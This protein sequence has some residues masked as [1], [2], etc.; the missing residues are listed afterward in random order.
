M[1]NA[2]QEFMQHVEDPESVLCATINHEYLGWYDDDIEP[3]SCNLPVNHTPEQ[4]HQFVESLDFNYDNGYGGQELFGY[5]WFK[6][7]T[8]STRG[9][10][11]GSEWWKH[12][13]LPAIPEN[14]K[15]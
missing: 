3:V 11:D 1:R 9:E 13:Q 12:H 4:Y 15:A 6:D 10:Y 5:I 2:K 8:W 14:L 7:G